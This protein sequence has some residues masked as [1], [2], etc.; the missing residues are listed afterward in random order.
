MKGVESGVIQLLNLFVPLAPL[1]GEIGFDMVTDIMI[2]LLK[3][4][5]VED[6]MDEQ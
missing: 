3:T 2:P 6:D 4:Y 1:I 5:G